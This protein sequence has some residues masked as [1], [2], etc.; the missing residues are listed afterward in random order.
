MGIQDSDGTVGLQVAYNQPYLHDSLTVQFY[1]PFL[2]A[3]P[4]RGAVQAGG[5]TVVEVTAY[6]HGIELGVY[7]ALLAIISNDPAMPLIEIPI[8]I[9]VGGVVHTEH[10]TDLTGLPLEL[11]FKGCHPN[12]FNPFTELNFDLPRAIHVD[13]KIYDIMGRQVEVLQDGLMKAGSHTV[14]WLASNVASGVYIYRFVA[15]DFTTSGK[16]V[17][18]K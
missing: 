16:M 6:S 18:V 2:R 9:D 10:A 15:D 3:E 1:H 4:T 17:L 5:N 7:D 11:A 14:Q 13:L 8:I 12:P